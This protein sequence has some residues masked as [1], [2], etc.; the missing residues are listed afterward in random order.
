MMAQ[1]RQS[2]KSM[3]DFMGCCDAQS[4]LRAELGVFL[5]SIVHWEDLPVILIGK[6]GK[7]FHITTMQHCTQSLLSRRRLS[8]LNIKKSRR[9]FKTSH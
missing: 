5:L 4:R 9:I 1:Q 2:T 7:S 6:G 8:I 3:N